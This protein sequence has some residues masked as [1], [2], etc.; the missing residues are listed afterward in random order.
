ML[1]SS[2]GHLINPERLLA[3]PDTK[4]CRDC[5]SI[6]ER[7]PKII[8]KNEPRKNSNES[9]PRTNK[10]GNLKTLYKCKK[11]GYSLN[12]NPNLKCAFCNEKSEFEISYR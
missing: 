12:L 1:C 3:L 10:I 2:C 8:S 9:S 6:N 5:Q 7:T 11:C 4:L